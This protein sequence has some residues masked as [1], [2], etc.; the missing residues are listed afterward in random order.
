MSEE[1]VD[2]AWLKQGLGKYSVGA[3]LGTLRHYGVPVDEAGFKQMAGEQFP[4]QIA[5]RWHG[6]WKGT[7]QF[8]RFP[9]YAA[10]E[11]WKRLQ[12]DRLSPSEYTEALALLLRELAR[13]L[14]GAPDA[15]VG[16]GLQK[17][18]GLKPRVPLKD[19]KPDPGFVTEVVAR[20][21]DA[22]KFFQ[23]VA[24][25]LARKGHVDDAQS[26]AE[27]EAFLFPQLAGIAQALVK[28]AKGEKEQA[29]KEILA[30]GND[31]TREPLSRLAALDALLHVEAWEPAIP[32]ARELFDMGEKDGDFH[33]ALE[34][35]ER[36]DFVLQKTNQ[37]A[38][39]R[40]FRERLAKVQEAH[41]QAHH[42]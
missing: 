33:L 37:H 22:M 40:A 20:L 38:E 34:A 10:D 26:V 9:V 31:T 15:A 2:K 23:R 27:L 29:T 6:S 28:N 3:I 12:P 42:H 14:E 24:L 32:L 41:D 17:M 5:E 8:S 39:R 36:L 1:R 4:L 35:G 19:G 18:D 30:I 7:G 13:L 25:E 21:G 16:P 11:L